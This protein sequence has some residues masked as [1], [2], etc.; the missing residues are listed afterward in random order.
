ML[1]PGSSHSSQCNLGP[2]FST[3]ERFSAPILP[4]RYSAGRLLYS[5][6]LLPAPSSHPRTVLAFS[7]F[8]LRVS[9]PPSPHIIG[10]RLAPL[11]ASP[12]ASQH[13]HLKVLS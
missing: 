12:W 13:F 3:F 11:L 6:R 1:R 9:S 4:Y 5:F 10:R 8:T 2:L 7:L